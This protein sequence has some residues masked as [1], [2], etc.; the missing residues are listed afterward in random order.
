MAFKWLQDHIQKTFR[1]RQRIEL[2]IPFETHEAPDT[3]KEL[4]SQHRDQD[5]PLDSKREE[6]N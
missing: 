5:D 1:R 4:L 6:D 3:M 2:D